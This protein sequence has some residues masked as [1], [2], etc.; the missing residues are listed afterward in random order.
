VNG[1]PYYDMSKAQHGTVWTF[2]DCYAKKAPELTSANNQTIPADCYCSNLPFSIK[3]DDVCDA[4]YYDVQIALDDQ[5]T[6]VVATADY[7]EGGKDIL[8]ATGPSYVVPNILT[9]QVT[10]YWRV[11]AHQAQTCQIIHSWWSDAGTF[12]VAP[13]A[14]QGAIDLIAPVSGA[15]DVGTKNV[16]FSW[17]LQ[18][19]ANKFDWVLSKNADLS[20]PVESKP[21]LTNRAYTCTVTL[22]HGT[23]YYW[24]VYAYQGSTLVSSSAVGTFTTGPTGPFCSAIDGRCFETEQELIAH[25]AD[26]EK[27]AGT[28]FWVWVVIGIG[29]VLVIVVIVLIFRTRRV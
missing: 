1:N 7:K 8:G 4:C 18:A 16:G 10:Y 21:G 20:S 9:C 26:L 2:E 28:P 12:T 23:T 6:D 17:N 27:P 19:S 13:S 14:D 25:N 24:H 5:F 22:D 11:R 29:A 3:W 15:T